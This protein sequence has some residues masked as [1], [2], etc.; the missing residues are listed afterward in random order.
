MMGN[1]CLSF[2]VRVL[3]VTNRK[4]YEMAESVSIGKTILNGQFS[5]K[6]EDVLCKYCKG[7][8]TYHQ[9]KSSLNYHLRTKHVFTTRAR[10]SEKDKHK[11]ELGQ[12]SLIQ[13][14]GLAKPMNQEKYDS[15]TNAITRSIALN[16]GPVN[17][18]TDEG[19][20]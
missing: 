12:T 1:S 4:F 16:G 9:S 14:W 11:K 15:L 20:I 17:I 19:N 13:F 7:E 8:F 3:S 6:S 18:V 5:F 10:T 2:L